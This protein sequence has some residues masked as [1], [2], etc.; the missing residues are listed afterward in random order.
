M[1][2]LVIIIDIVFVDQDRCGGEVRSARRTR[3][4]H[5]RASYDTSHASLFRCCSLYFNVRL[6]AA[7]RCSIL[8]STV[9]ALSQ[10]IFGS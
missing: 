3:A 10:T 5:L 7:S 6:V 4:E 9:L 2:F 1:I 8:D